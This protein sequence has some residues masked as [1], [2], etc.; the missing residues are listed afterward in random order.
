MS[1]DKMLMS[2]SNPYMKTTFVHLIDYEAKCCAK[3]RLLIFWTYQIRLKTASDI[4]RFDL[5]II[6]K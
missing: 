6:E 3:A 1:G 5:C 4:T 2:G